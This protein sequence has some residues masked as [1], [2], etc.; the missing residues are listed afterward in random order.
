VLGPSHQNPALAPP[1]PVTLDDFGTST[2]DLAFHDNGLA[3]N[4][5]TRRQIDKPNTGPLYCT[6]GPCVD[7][8]CCGPKGVCGYGPDFCGDGCTSKCDATAMCGEYSEDA[9]MPCGMKLCCSATGWCG[10]KSCPIKPL[11]IRADSQ[12]SN[13]E[14]LPQCGSSAWHSALPGRIRLVCYHWQT[15]LYQ[16]KWKL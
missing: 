6:D 9:N 12:Y 1:I 7:D 5:L 10:S 13:G 14:L 3:Q 16:G 11:G 4:N 15:F 8:S 2:I